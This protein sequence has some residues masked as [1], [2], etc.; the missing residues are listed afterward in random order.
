MWIQSGKGEGVAKTKIVYQVN[1]NF[2]TVN[3]YLASLVEG[4]LIEAVNG[5][6]KRY[7]I[8]EK[9]NGLLERLNE[10]DALIP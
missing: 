10:I 3:P 2:V 6:F 4:G 1:L 9:G 7:R 5:P 8:T